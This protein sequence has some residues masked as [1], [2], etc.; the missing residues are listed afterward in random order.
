[1]ADYAA[2]KGCTVTPT[3]WV[4]Q[5]LQEIPSLILV[6]EKA[7]EVFKHHKKAVQAVIKLG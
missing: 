6:K 7:A 4:I 2:S 1:M 5:H 3:S